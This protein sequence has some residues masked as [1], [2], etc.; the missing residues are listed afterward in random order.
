MMRR[1]RSLSS[2][3]ALCHAGVVHVVKDLLGSEHG[4][5]VSLGCLA[6]ARGSIDPGLLN[7]GRVVGIGALI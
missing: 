2:V 1:V 6:D 3:A 7:H 4:A 5:G